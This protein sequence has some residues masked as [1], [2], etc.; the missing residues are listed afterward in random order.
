MVEERMSDHPLHASVG[1]GL[2]SPNL[3]GR[4]RGDKEHALGFTLSIYIES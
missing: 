2:V 3:R 1:R 4:A